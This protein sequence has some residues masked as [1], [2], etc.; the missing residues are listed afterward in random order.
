[1]DA[2]LLD[3]GLC[4]FRAG[5]LATHLTAADAVI[6][7]PG[8]LAPEQVSSSVGELGPWTDTFALGIVLYYAL[9]AVRAFPSRAVADAAYEALNYHPLP[10]RSLRPD[11]PRA[12]E[13]VL[14][15]AMAKLPSER[16]ASAGEL[17]RDFRAACSD[18]TLAADTLS[19]ALAIAQNPPAKTLTGESAVGSA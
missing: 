9:T 19:R 8:Y 17:A 5:E 6:G 2:R 11:L 18:G 13:A 3:F 12:L 10:I 7:T 14:T 4:S 15:R 16:Y 1:M